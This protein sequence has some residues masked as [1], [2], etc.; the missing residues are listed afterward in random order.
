MTQITWWRNFFHYDLKKVSVYC[1]VQRNSFG[2]LFKWCLNLW[3]IHNLCFLIPPQVDVLAIRTHCK[4]VF[5]VPF[6][7]PGAATGDS[8]GWKS[9][10]G[11]GRYRDNIKWGC[12]WTQE[13]TL[14]PAQRWNPTL[15]GFTKMGKLCQGCHTTLQRWTIVR[16]VKFNCTFW[17]YDAVRSCIILYRE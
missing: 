4:L 2:L 17:G 13:D 3:L 16:F 15:P 8:D 11:P 10:L 1:R 5:K 14:P 9:D 6:N 12:W 7:E